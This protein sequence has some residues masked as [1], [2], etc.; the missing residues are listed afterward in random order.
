M[1]KKNLINISLI[2]KDVI[3]ILFILQEKIRFL[4]SHIRTIRKSKYNKKD[5]VKIRDEYQ[6]LEDKLMNARKPNNANSS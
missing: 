4:N 6:E 3:N 5:L 1:T 2:E